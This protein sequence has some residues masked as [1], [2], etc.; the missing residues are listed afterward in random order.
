MN[1]LHVGQLCLHIQ[2]L[3]PVTVCLQGSGHVLASGLYVRLGLVVFGEVSG[4]YGTRVVV[5]WLAVVDRVVLLHAGVACVPL[6]CRFVRGERA[7]SS[8][9]L[10]ETLTVLKPQK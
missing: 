5:L 4:L 7:R 2:R 3:C 1:I 6:H 8:E 9:E 10:A